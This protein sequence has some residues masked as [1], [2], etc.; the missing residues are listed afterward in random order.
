[1]AAAL[2][3]AL[4][5]IAVLSLRDLARHERSRRRRFLLGS[6]RVLTALAAWV[7]AVQPQWTGERVR[8]E[9]GR[10]AVLFDASRSMGVKAGDVSR[11]E[12]ARRLAER[13]GKPSGRVSFH[14][15]GAEV[16]SAS[17]EDVAAEYP[18]DSDETRIVPAVREVAVGDGPGDLGAVVVVSDGADTEGPPV[19]GGVPEGVRVHAVAVGDDVPLRDDAIVRVQADPVAFLR[20][21]AEVRVVVRSSGGGVESLPV[22]LRR[23]GQVVRERT[24]ELDDEGRGAVDLRFT[25]ERLG[26]AVYQVSIP[27]DPEDAVPENNERAFLVRVKRDRLRVLLV[28]GRPSWDVRFLRAFLKRDPSIDLVSF[29]ILRTGADLTMASPDELALIPFPTDEL[30][31]EHLGSFDVVFFQ[32]FDYGPYGMAPYLPQIRDYVHRGGSFAMIGGDL[33]FASGG[34]PGTP[35]AEILPVEMPAAGASDSDLL[36]TGTFRP[37]LAPDLMRHPLLELLPDPAAN[38]SAWGQLGSLEGANLLTGLKG[39]ARALLRHPDRQVDGKPMPVLAVGSAGEGRVMALGVDSSWRWGITTAGKT[40]DASAY[41][42]FWGRA[43]RWLARDPSLRPCQIETDRGR[44][45]PEA[46]LRGEAWVRDEGYEAVDDRRIR[47]EVLDDAGEVLSDSEARTDG[48]GRARATVRAPAHPGGY[49]LAVRLEDETDPRCDEGFVVEA[50]GLELADPRARPEWLRALAD[51]TDGQ[52]H[53]D[54][55]SAPDLDG[56][57]SSRTQSLGFVTI[58]PFATPWAFLIVVALLVA[59]WAVRRRWGHR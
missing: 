6:L 18:A 16:R 28:A 8:R 7:V 17:S 39:D 38:A 46:R 53:P 45:G 36:V 5:L 52:F 22:T 1:M 19:E 32:N 33:S 49:R 44:Y 15:F 27:V 59:E 9:P 25:P 41:E 30:F 29:F 42:R 13:W 54:P 14:T 35:I 10:L 55:G 24:V 20:Q 50:S 21:T 31:R 57:D 43:L 4:G 56:F 58:A 34:Y 40:G 11:A 48:N 47:F 3:G 37:E 51:A 12:R 26:R 2:L 23:R